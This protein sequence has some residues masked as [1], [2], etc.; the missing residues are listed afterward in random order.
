MKIYVKSQTSL[1]EENKGENTMEE[2]KKVK[3]AEEKAKEKTMQKLLAFIS[4]KT[5]ARDAF[6]PDDEF[7]KKIGYEGMSEDEAIHKCMANLISD[8]TLTMFKIKSSMQMI[9]NII[10]CAEGKTI[11]QIIKE[12]E[13]QD[14]KRKEIK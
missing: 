12:K 6:T 5:Y 8:Y 1:M 13:E 3:T 4:A 2:E 7:V 10:E 9:F 11:D 14:Q